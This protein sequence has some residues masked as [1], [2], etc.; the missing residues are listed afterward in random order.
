M[1]LTFDS[2]WPLLFLLIIPWLWWVRT[3]SAV[4]LTP[5]HLRIST[6]LRSIIVLALTA[7]LM[8]PVLYKTSTYVSVVYLLDVSQSVAPAAI[9]KAIDWIQKTNST[10]KPDHSEFVAFGSNSMEFDNVDDLKKVKVANHGG[11][12]ILDQ[13]KSDLS[14]ALDAAMEDL[15]PMG[16][17]PRLQQAA[18]VFVAVQARLI[19][20]GLPLPRGSS[21]EVINASPAAIALKQRLM[22]RIQRYVDGLSLGEPVRFSEVM[23]SMMNEPG[24]TDVQDL[25]LVPSPLAPGVSPPGPGDNV[26][27][28]PTQ[29]ATFVDSDALLQVI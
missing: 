16:I 27:I 3:R 25:L 6:L 14:A 11:T 12:G 9:Q 4:D 5:K 28:R 19:V 2:Y 24:V 7:A 20:R 18:P 15:R 17:L 13:S 26:T 10:G 1:R 29:V 23:W 22:T 21:G 8:Q